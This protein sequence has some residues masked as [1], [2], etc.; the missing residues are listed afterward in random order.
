[1]SRI[2]AIDPQ[3][4]S[5]ETAELFKTAEKNMGAV[6]NI[7]RVLGNSPAVLKAYLTLSDIL[8]ETSFDPREREAIALTV[9]W[10]QRFARTTVRRRTATV[11]SD[12]QGERR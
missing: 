4:A 3:S 2:P 7:I 6:P 1:M 5:G 11:R 12:P 10:R 8:S 9:A